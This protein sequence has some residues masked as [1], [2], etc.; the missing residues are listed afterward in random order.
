M[1]LR[2]RVVAAVIAALTVGVAVLGYLHLNNRDQNDLR[3]T[4]L[5]SATQYTEELAT[6]DFGDPGANLDRVTA[7]STEE[8][9]GTYRDV[10]TKLQD[11]LTTG[12]GT[13]TGHVVAAGIVELTDDRA[14]VAVFLDQQV[15]NL[16]APD[17]R[18]DSSRMII[19]LERS[20]DRWLLASAEPR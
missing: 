8:F 12:Q 1:T 14:T 3:S 4:A 10:S 13:A 7:A 11:L 9:A 5:A 16:A 2:T 17:G 18:T 15:R 6:Y 19:E 20:G